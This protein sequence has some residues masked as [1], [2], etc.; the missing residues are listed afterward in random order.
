M[1]CTIS[2]DITA[3]V[4]LIRAGELVAFATE[5]VYGLGANAL[6]SEAVARI[7]EVKQRPH[8]DPLIVHI[9]NV[10]QLDQLTL[11]LSKQAEKLAEQ[12]WPGPLTL[13]VPKTEVVPDLVTSGLGSVAIRI[14]AHPIARQ[15]LEAT[16]LPIAAPSANK[17]GCLSPT[18]AQHVEEQLGNE[19]K[20]ILDGGPCSVG[21]ESTVIQCIDEIPVLLR[22][23]GI[24]L[25]EIEACIGRVRIAKIEDHAEVKSPESPGMLPKHYAPR[26]RLVIADKLDQ[27]PAKG[28][29]GLLSLYPLEETFL[30]GSQFSAQEILSPAGDLRV[31]AAKLFTALRNLDSA[32]VENIVALRMPEKGLGRTINNRLDRA[33][34]S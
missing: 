13:V 31:A 24:S 16:K 30:K 7:F 15:L 14:P 1:K 12:F 4:D 33:A 2:Q 10:N 21:V 20:L 25:E 8:F 17:F 26:A 18:L 9:S 34:E 11:G 22:P 23:G 19:I 5:T 3:G 32:G 28:V 27:L 6:D 29:N